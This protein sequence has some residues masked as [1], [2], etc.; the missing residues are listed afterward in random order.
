LLIQVEIYIAA[1]SHQSEEPPIVFHQILFDICLWRII[2]IP[3]QASE[4]KQLPP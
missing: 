1:D 2:Q 3:K 4:R